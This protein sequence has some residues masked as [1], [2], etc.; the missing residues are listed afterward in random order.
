M[1][2]IVKSYYKLRHDCL[3]V[4]MEQFGSHWTNFHEILYLSIFRKSVEQ[5]QVL[6]KSDKNNGYSTWGPIYTFDH[7]MLSFCLEWKMFLTKVVEKIETH[8]TF[9]NFLFNVTFMK[10]C[11]KLSSRRTGDR[12]WQ[13]GACALHIGYL[14]QQTHSNF[15]SYLLL[16][17]CN[18]SS[19]NALQC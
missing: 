13:Y 10:K 5:T 1:R 16:F 8:F 19:K 12:F 6:L 18:G 11:G 3:S 9:N 14:R 17:R 15:G 7:I 4:R 2:N